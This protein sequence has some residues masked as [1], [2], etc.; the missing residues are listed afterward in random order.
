MDQAFEIAGKKFG[1]RLMVGTGR[2]RSMEEMV[3]SIE[4]TGAE[5][6]TVAIRRLNLDN[7]NEKN[8]LVRAH[9]TPW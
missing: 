8:I 4:A 1:T 9:S 3:A 6:I 2:H 5:I 7:P